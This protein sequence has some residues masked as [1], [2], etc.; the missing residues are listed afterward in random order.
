MRPG[1]LYQAAYDV[2]AMDIA[3][4]PLIR[5]F[6]LWF[7]GLHQHGAVIRTHKDVILPVSIGIG[8]AAHAHPYLFERILPAQ[9]A[10]ANLQKD[11]LH[12]IAGD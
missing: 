2:S 1:R 5:H 8:H 7:E 4:V 11:R 10:G 3:E 12:G 6:L 9:F